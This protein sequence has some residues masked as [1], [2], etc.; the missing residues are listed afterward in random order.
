M[1]DP[2]ALTSEDVRRI[3]AM[4]TGECEMELPCGSIHLK[5]GTTSVSIGHHAIP[6]SELVRANRS[7]VLYTPIDGRLEKLQFFRG[8]LFKLAPTGGFP[9]LEID[10]IRMH[11]AKDMLPEEEAE[12]K[13]G[14]LNIKTGC[15]VLDICTGLGYSAQEAAR[16]GARVVTLEKYSAVIELARRNPCS[17]DL[18][19]FVSS[20]LIHIMVCDAARSI[21]NFPDSFFDGIIHDPP[22]FSFAGELYSLRFYKQLRRIIR[23]SG[24][25]LHY[26]GQPGFR[27]RRRDLSRGV[28]RRLLEAGFRT[29]WVERTRSILANP[30]QQGTKGSRP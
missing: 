17:T 29:R 25:L 11:R 15:R 6:K 1:N 2:V 10:G 12:I 26:T 27:Y 8:H 23:E 18:F 24:S 3:A 7:N 14:C 5:V 20:G 19:S 16:I 22:T 28:G 4:K 21:D 13:V 9:A 30:V